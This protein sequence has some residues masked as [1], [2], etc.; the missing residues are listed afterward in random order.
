MPTIYK[1][2]KPGASFT[3]KFSGSVLGVYDLIG[4]KSGIVSITIDEGQPVEVNRFD[5]YAN[6]YRKN[7]FFLKPLSD[8]EHKV[9]FLV[10]GKQFDKASIL[11]K[12][13]LTMTNPDQYAENSWF[14]GDVLIV[15]KL[16]K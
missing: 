13:F 15:G 11:A 9:T 2:T 12:R 6:S 14:V 3:I 5:A 4:P 1:A 10:T 16:L 7:A 8:G